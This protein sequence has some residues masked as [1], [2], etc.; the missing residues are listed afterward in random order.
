MRRLVESEQVAA[1]SEGQVPER[2][3]SG[4]E[5]GNMHGFAILI[6]V[7]PGW[8]AKFE[9]ASHCLWITGRDRLIYL[10]RADDCSNGRFIVWGYERLEEMGM[11]PC[12]S[13]HVGGYRLA[14]GT[15]PNFTTI[16]GGRQID[17]YPEGCFERTHVDAVTK[18]EAIVKAL[19]IVLAANPAPS[20]EPPTSEPKAET[21][22][23]HQ[24][25]EG[26]TPSV[27]EGEGEER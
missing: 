13:S 1:C 16:A 6:Y 11:A 22:S 4:G 14:F 25:N 26:L 20:Q 18:G 3:H 7:L 19:T 21:G 9:D 27:T 23:S 2:G 8:G 12:L 17:T 15:M 10:P 24:S 5:F